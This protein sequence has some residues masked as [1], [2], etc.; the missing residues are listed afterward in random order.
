MKEVGED[1]SVTFKPGDSIRVILGQF[2]GFMGRVDTV[3]PKTGDV[4]VV[5]QVFGR[6]VPVSLAASQFRSVRR[7]S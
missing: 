1:V 7:G 5:L 4:R 3:H 6:E 2:A